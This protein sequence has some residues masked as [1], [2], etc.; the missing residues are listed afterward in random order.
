MLYF[1][2]FFETIS[3]LSG[4]NGSPYEHNDTGLGLE[5]LDGED[6]FRPIC[7]SITIYVK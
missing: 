5:E 1:F 6:L 3:V 4:M 7:L 2:L